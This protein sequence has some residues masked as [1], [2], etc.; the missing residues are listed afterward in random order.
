MLW[1]N[2]LATAVSSSASVFDTANGFQGV[3]HFSEQNL[4]NVNDA[5]GNH[6]DG[7]PSDTAP[8]SATGAIGIGKGFN[9]ASSYFDMKNTASGKLNFPENGTYTVSAWVYAD[10][11]DNRF[12]SIVGKSDNQYFLK[13]KQYYPPNPMRWEFAEYHSIAGWQ[14]TDTIATAREWKYLVGVRRGQSQCFSL[15]GIL[16]DSV[17]QVKA[18]S[19]PRNTGDDVTIGKFLTFSAIDAGYCPFKGIIDEVRISSVARSP[20]WVRLCFMNQKTSD[21]LVQFR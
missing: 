17:I 5:T 13:L 14:I 10:T 6:F 9:G 18:D 7:T 15:D 20:D 19:L 16:V 1:G 11:L 4:A 21:A 2:P 3:W 12:H 8:V